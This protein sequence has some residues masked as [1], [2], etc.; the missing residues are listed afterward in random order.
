MQIHF[1]DKEAAVAYL[2]KENLKFEEEASCI[3]EQ[4][5]AME[6]HEKEEREK[7][8][9]LPWW[10]FRNDTQKRHRELSWMYTKDRLHGKHAGLMQQI[11]KN[12]ELIGKILTADGV[13]WYS[14]EV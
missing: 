12:K 13:E 6:R 3:R 11:T 1:K 10:K 14:V 8:E 4:L 5:N 9:A 2:E 7:D